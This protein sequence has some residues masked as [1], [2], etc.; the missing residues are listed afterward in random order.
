MRIPPVESGVSVV[1]TGAM[2]PPIISPEWL[3]RHKVLAQDLVDGAEIQVIHKE[4]TVFRCG[5]CAIHVDRDR[6]QAATTEAPYIRISDLV[7]KVFGELLPNTP[8]NALGINVNVHFNAPSSIARDNLGTTLVPPQNWGQWGTRVSEEIA[9]AGVRHAASRG[10][11]ARG[12]Q[13][14]TPTKSHGGVAS[15]TMQQRQLDDRDEGALSVRVEPSAKLTT[16]GVFI[17]VN[18]HYVISNN[19]G[20]SDALAY[21]QLLTDRFD[22]SIQRSED[23]IDQIMEL[24]HD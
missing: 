2:N 17:E 18:D 13:R 4:V 20:S 19:R 11:S 3:A 7:A 9:S 6:F 12:R 23:I 15:V 21:A 5:W 14:A 22:A 24:V 8:V 16:A 10:R 1:L